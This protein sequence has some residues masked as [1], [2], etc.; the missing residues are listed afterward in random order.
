MRDILVV[1]V[2]PVIE[3]SNDARWAG[4]VRFTSNLQSTNRAMLRSALNNK[5]N[6]GYIACLV[7]L[8]SILSD[9]PEPLIDQRLSYSWH[10]CERNLVGAGI[11]T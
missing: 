2:M 9:I 4:Y 7:N 1:L 5:W 6:G 11:R 8:K 3:L 10:L